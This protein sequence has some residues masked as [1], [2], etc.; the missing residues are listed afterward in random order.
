M[1]ITNEFGV[2][3]PD[4]DRP[5]SSWG[6]LE[7]AN[8][9]AGYLASV[10]Q[11]S[12]YTI[13]R[14]LGSKR[15][16][17]R[18]V[19]LVRAQQDGHFIEGCRRLGI[20]DEPHAVMCA[21]YHALSNALGGLRMRY[22]IESPHKAWVFYLPSPCRPDAAAESVDQA[23]A[24]FANWHARNGELLGNQGLVFVV[25]HAFAR[26]DY[27]NAGY[28]LDTGRAVEAEDRCRFSWGERIPDELGRPG[29]DADSWPEARR[30]K[31]LQRYWLSWLR[32]AAQASAQV[33][34]SEGIDCVRH[35]ITVATYSWLDRLVAAFASDPTESAPARA[36]RVFA[37]VHTMCGLDVDLDL[38][39]RDALVELGEELVTGVVDVAG[40]MDRDLGN[41]LL[42]SWAGPCRHLGAQVGREV[43]RSGSVWTFNA[44]VAESPRQ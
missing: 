25:T 43:R 11:A 6:A 8:V 29:F 1:E 15:V 30:A 24:D 27:Y 4:V 7:R 21:K 12:N 41:V 20:T 31:V 40:G 28:W 34:G 17:E 35:G 9:A 37:G 33:L 18:D 3:L 44:Q 22:A 13:L 19:R 2:V 5:A 38:D 39:G 16:A 14:E 26:G 23:I 42:A 10:M 36:A 32:A